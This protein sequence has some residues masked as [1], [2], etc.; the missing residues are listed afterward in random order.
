M[1]SFV[2]PLVRTY[3]AFAKRAPSDKQS[4]SSS[5]FI[6]SGADGRGGKVTVFKPPSLSQVYT[7]NNIPSFLKSLNVSVEITLPEHRRIKFL[8]HSASAT[9][10][11]PSDLVLVSCREV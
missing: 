1:T 11:I 9:L 3:G 6:V 4:A 8:P 2:A 10:W 5:A 7:L